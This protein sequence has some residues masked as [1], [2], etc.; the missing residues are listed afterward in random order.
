[1]SGTVLTINLN[2]LTHNYEYLRSKI[3]AKV[4][5]LAVVKAVAY[6]S[7]AV[8]IAR[9]L[10]TLGVDYFGVA[11]AEEGAALR[12]SGIKTPILVLHPQPHNFKLLLKYKLE[13]GI[14]S[15]RVLTTFA[16]FCMDNQQENFPVHIK[17]NSGLNRL[18]FSDA[19][20]PIILDQVEEANL[21]IK[22]LF[23]HL[24]ASEDKNE[25]PFTMQQI[26][27]F[28]QFSGALQSQ[29]MNDPMVH[30]S[31]TSGILNY[32]EAHF[33]MVRT[34]IGLYGF[35]ND[36]KYD[37]NLKP[38]A[39][40]TSVISQIHE[41]PAGGSLG[42]NRGF[43][44]E[45]TIKSATITLGHADG[46]T[47]I[48][49]HKKGFVFINGQ[50]APIL[51]NVCMDMIMVDVTAINCNEGDTVIIFDSEHTAAALAEAAGTISYELITDIGPRVKR[52]IT[53]K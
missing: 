19:D 21:S 47:R 10:E 4:K 39:S 49:G 33:S 28:K 16:Q 13:P 45:T 26:K 34:G 36:A 24:A 32:P 5:L 35:G 23:S 40:L 7:D 42:Y 29:M 51:G 9:H 43:I 18:G 2:N 20:I 1:M 38:V 3:N 30:Q 22:S 50:K 44:A 31:N 48:Y 52:I 14:Y 15:K 37:Q 53:K 12:Q 17:Y 25:R 8:Q 46:I 11:Y 41:I 6:G 27:R